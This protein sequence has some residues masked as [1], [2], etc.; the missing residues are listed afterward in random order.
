MNIDLIPAGSNPPHSINVLPEYGRDPRTPDK[1]L[2]GKSPVFS[3]GEDCR[4]LPVLQADLPAM[5]C[6]RLVAVQGQQRDP[7]IVKLAAGIDVRCHLRLSTLDG[8]QPM[9]VCA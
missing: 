1:L 6:G 7:Y 9:Q 3:G 5:P 4:D 8:V 2:D